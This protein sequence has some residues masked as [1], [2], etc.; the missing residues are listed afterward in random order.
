MILETGTEFHCLNYDNKI[1]NLH[2]DT[3]FGN[4]RFH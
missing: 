2:F 4:N 1:E 3:G